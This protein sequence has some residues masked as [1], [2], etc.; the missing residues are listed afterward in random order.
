MA[1]K[2]LEEYEWRSFFDRLSKDLAG[3]RA[4]IE[5]ASLGIGHQ[6]E[7]KWIAL[8]GIA[9]HPKDDVVEITLEGHDHLIRKPREIWVDDDGPSGLTCMGV[10]DADGGRHILLVHNTLTLPPA[11]R[12][13]EIGQR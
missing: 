1:L 4:E 3:K 13:D 6:V 5:R 7:E 9:Y 12:R 10:I 8:L 2:K 11:G